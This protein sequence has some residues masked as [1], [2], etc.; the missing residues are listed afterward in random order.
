MR[1]ITY[2]EG[3]LAATMD[4]LLTGPSQDDLMKGFFTLIPNETVINRISLKDGIGLDR[5][6]RSLS[7]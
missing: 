2:E 7:L 4:S 5:R 6:E 1:T 3:L